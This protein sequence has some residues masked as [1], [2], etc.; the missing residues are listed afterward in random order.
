ME[1]E[2]SVPQFLRPGTSLDLQITDLAYR[3][4]GVARHGKLVVFVPRTAPGD[5]ARVRITAV[6]RGFAE[7]RVEEIL[8]PSPQRVRPRC[9]HF[10]VCGGCAYQ[11]LEAGRQ[12]ESK[13][14]QIRET[15]RR[16]GHLEEAPIL[17]PLSAPSAYAYRNRLELHVLRDARGRTRLGLHRADNPAQTFAIEECLIASPAVEALRAALEQ[18]LNEHPVSPYDPLRRRG[19]LIRAGLRSTSSGETLLELHTTRLDTPQLRRLAA[20]LSRHPGLRGIVCITERETRRGSALTRQCL[21]GGS[22]LWDELCGLKLE[23]PAGAFA[24]THPAMAGELYGESV[25]ALGAVGGAACLDLFCGVGVMSLLLQRQGAREVVGVESQAVAVQAASRNA[26]GAGAAGCRFIHASVESVLGKSP[27]PLSG[28]SFDYVLVNPPRG[29]L[30]TRALREIVRLAPARLAYI[31]CDPAT[32][33]RDLRLL[34]DGGFRVEWVRPLDLFPQTAHVE[35][36][37]ALSRP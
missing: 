14:R 35:S 26:E 16:I 10:S 13:A 15:L 17:A 22:S 34:T 20:A 23:F 21:W 36:V 7:G 24:Q 1:T 18:A 32:L 37:T 3:G 28:G 4:S 9:R 30:S 33:A 6:R 31:S 2:G 12:A 5:R 27:R 19:T 8:Q 11:H 29:G 25:R